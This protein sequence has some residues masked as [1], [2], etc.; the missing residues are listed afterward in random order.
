MPRTSQK[1]L[2]DRSEATRDQILQ[3]AAHEF[4]QRGLSDA[5]VE[6]I[7]SWA[8]VN[9]ALIY[10]YFSNKQGLYRAVIEESAR[11]FIE[12]G[13]E[14]L[15]APGSAGERLLHLAL[16]NFNRQLLQFKHE[17]VMQREVQRDVETLRRVAVD[18]GRPLSDK[19]QEVVREGVESGEICDLDWMLVVHLLFGTTASYFRLGPFLRTMSGKVPM[20]AEFLAFRRK[21][22][23]HVLGKVLFVDSSHGALLAEQALVSC[24]MTS[25]DQYLEW[26]STL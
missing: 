18:I 2:T 6:S 1:G 14:V 16:A 17:A 9:L 26:M 21:S 3:A 15:T 11:V 8:K 7:A 25:P 12:R 4:S 20:D 24:P 22:I 19:L 13:L 23:L 10:Y 5:R